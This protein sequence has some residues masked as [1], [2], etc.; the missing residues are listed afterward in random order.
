MQTTDGLRPQSVPDALAASANR[1]R[2]G[3]GQDTDL[4]LS[5]LLNLGDGI[6]NTTDETNNDGGNTGEGDRSIEEDQTGQSNGKLVQR[7]NHGVCRRGGD[8]HTPCGGVGDEDR[9]ETGKNHGHDNV[10]A[11]FHGEVAVNVGRGPILSQEREN[12]EDGNR[13]QV[14]VEHGWEISS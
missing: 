3:R 1:A 5:V 12:D 10:V 9:R 14:V 7:A 13:Q 8:T 6:H 4:R 11:A 2:V